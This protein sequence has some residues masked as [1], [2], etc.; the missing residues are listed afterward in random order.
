MGDSADFARARRG[1]G[2]GATLSVLAFLA[3]VAVSVAIPTQ[4]ENPRAWGVVGC[5]LVTVWLS[6]QLARRNWLRIRHYRGDDLPRV[7]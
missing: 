3:T 4:G 5:G 2:W 7:R 6:V 1:V